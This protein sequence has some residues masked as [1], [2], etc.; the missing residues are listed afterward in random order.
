MWTEYLAV[1]E[2]TARSGHKYTSVISVWGWTIE[3]A[4]RAAEAIGEKADE[5]VET[6][7]L[8]ITVVNRD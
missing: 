5:P 1:L 2:V 3:D 8:G 6:R 4:A 7:L